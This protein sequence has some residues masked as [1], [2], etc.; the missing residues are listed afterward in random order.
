MKKA[1]KTKIRPKQRNTRIQSRKDGPFPMWTRLELN[2]QV[3]KDGPFPLVGFG[4]YWERVPFETV[5]QSNKG[6]KAARTGVV[7]SASE[8]SSQFPGLD[9][10][11]IDFGIDEVIFVAL[12]A[13]PTNGYMVQI[14]QVLYFTDRGPKFAGP[15]TVVDY[16]EYRTTGQS[17]VESYP[18]HVIKLRKLDGVEIQFSRT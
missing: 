12:G 16:S 15:L 1:T 13:K 6:P 17:D 8:F 14:S 9:A 18:L 11:S 4:L 3:G 2:N 7:R 5:Y 10:S